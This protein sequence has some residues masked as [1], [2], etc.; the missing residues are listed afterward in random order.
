MNKNEGGNMSEFLKK[1]VDETIQMLVDDPDDVDTKVSVSTK[2]VILQIQVG[3][4]D[5]GKV[6]GKKGRT[7]ESLKILTLAVKN[8][9]F[10]QDS[11]NV[12]LEI[13]EDEEKT[14]N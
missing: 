10:P 8:T 4:E 12:A 13:L 11:R 9:N 5:Y 6:I 1:F 7:I 3:K 2:N 14:I